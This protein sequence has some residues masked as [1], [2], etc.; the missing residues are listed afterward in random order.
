M[1]YAVTVLAANAAAYLIVAFINADA[2]W[3]NDIFSK[4]P[5]QRIAL[6]FGALVL[7]VF[8]AMIY[9]MLTEHHR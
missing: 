1:G 5:Q 6:L 7:S 4:M 8:A 9:A 2:W 3:L